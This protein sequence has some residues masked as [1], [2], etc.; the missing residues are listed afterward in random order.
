MRRRRRRGVV[1]AHAALHLVAVAKALEGPEFLADNR[2]PL[3]QQGRAFFRAVLELV[4]I[5]GL[6]LLNLRQDQTALIVLDEVDFDA[7][8]AIDEGETDF[9][10]LEL[11]LDQLNRGIFGLLA[12]ADVE[13]ESEALRLVNKTMRAPVSRKIVKNR[14]RRRPAISILGTIVRRRRRRMGPAVSILRTIMGR[15]QRLVV[16]IVRAMVG[17]RPA[18]VPIIRTIVGRRPAVSIVRAVRTLAV[19]IIRTMRTLAVTVTG[20]AVV[21]RPAV[22]LVAMITVTTVFSVVPVQ[23]LVPINNL[24]RHKGLAEG[25]LGRIQLDAVD[26]KPVMIGIGLSV[27][28]K[29]QL[30]M[31]RAMDLELEVRLL[32]AAVLDQNGAAG[33]FNLDELGVGDLKDVGVA[34]LGDLGRDKEC[35]GRWEGQDARRNGEGLQQ[36]GAD[37]AIIKVWVRKSVLLSI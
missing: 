21:G 31:V 2:Q 37:G 20:V 13:A 1:M 30:E 16:S 3:A 36:H 4:R 5:L 23:L 32:A 28:G 25:I 6:A 26:E 29:Q 34:G 11:K 18:V 24:G 9:D 15:R 7:G 17:R 22:S 14:Q 35:V 8:D 27:D 19:S 10:D 33:A 12:R